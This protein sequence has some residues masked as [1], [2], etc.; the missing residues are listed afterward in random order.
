M[1]SIGWID[2]SKRDRDK[3]RGVLDLLEEDGAVDELGVGTVRDAFSDILFPGTSTIQTRAKY[4]F[5]TAYICRDLERGEK[6]LRPDAFIA[7]LEEK[8]IELID[9]L[10]VD[11]AD[12]VIGKIAREK[13]QRKP[14][15]I[16]WN[17]LRA[18]GIFNDDLTLSAYA[19]KFCGRKGDAES[20]KKGGRHREEGGDAD[21]PADD[22]DTGM[23]GAS[24]WRGVPYSHD[25]EEEVNINLTAEE[26]CF[27]REKIISSPN[28]KVSDSL[29]ALVLRENRKSFAKFT[30][31]E[32][33]D[34]LKHIM[35]DGMR[36]DYELARDFSRFVFGTQ[37][38]YNVIYSGGKNEDAK[39]LWK[40]Y[41][42]ERPS[43]N[44]DEV[45]ARIRPHLSLMLFLRAFQKSLD[46]VDALD[47]LIIARE[48]DIKTPARAK[49]T[50][51][52]LYQYKDGDESINMRRLTYRLHT[53]VTIVRDIFEG[54]KNNA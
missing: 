39:F 21:E 48:S 36:R 42:K 41:I 35:P 29:L 14:S 8:E 53:A 15:S 30:D 2:F 37:I 17:A 18:Y 10:D 47:K 34:E 6:R 28:R 46:D 1:N 40:E 50:N 52:E 32:K 5:L 16:Y 20:Q 13:L 19:A 45:E 43:V 27:L 49:L 22:S 31:F 23:L 24:F 26:A 12:G 25:W 4:L 11:G 51:K 9:A 33:I 7:K 44:L 54:M 38:R 3:V